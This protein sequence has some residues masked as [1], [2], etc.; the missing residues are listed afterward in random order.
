M[1]NSQCI[2]ALDTGF[3]KPRKQIANQDNQKIMGQMGQMGQDW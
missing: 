1:H 2:I 3:I